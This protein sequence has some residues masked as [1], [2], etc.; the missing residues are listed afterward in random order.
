MEAGSNTSTVALQV[1]GGDE[2]GTQCLG[3]SLGDIDTGTWSSRFGGWTQSSVIK[4]LRNPKELKT[5]FNLVESSKEGYCSK[6]AVLSTMMMTYT[7]SIGKG[8]VVPMLN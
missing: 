3:A 2:K 8:K 1:V 4:L 5:G 6:R 7:T